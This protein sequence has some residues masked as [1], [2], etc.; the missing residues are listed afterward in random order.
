[1]IFLTAKYNMGSLWWS[2]PRPEVNNKT[3][4]VSKTGNEQDDLENSVMMH[5]HAHEKPDWNK[6]QRSDL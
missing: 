5:L 2:Q 1:M 6:Q 3:K 4:D